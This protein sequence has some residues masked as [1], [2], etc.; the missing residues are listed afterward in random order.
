MN[1][2]SFV[3]IYG[4]EIEPYLTDLGLLRIA[5][6]KD[7]P[8][9]Y[10]G[11]LDYERA[12]LDVYLGCP[13][14]FVYIVLHD[15]QVV[16]ATTAL[17][18]AAET[19]EVQ[20]PFLDAGMAIDTIMYFGESILLHPYRGLGLGHSFFDAREEFTLRS[21]KFLTTCFCAVDRPMGHPLWPHGYRGNEAFWTKR[22]YQLNPQFAV[23]NVLERPR[24]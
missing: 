12:Y 19:K 5:V 15:K 14:S 13:E 18:L 11:N 2:L 6:F 4:E 9:L 7:F 20:Q 1:A 17:P 8:Y 3:K 10:A 23:P 16:G 24:P 22:G 21:G